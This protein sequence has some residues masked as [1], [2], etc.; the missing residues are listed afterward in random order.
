[1]S[2][3]KETA[4][5]FIILENGGFFDR[6]GFTN[7]KKGAIM[8]VPNKTEYPYYIGIGVFCAFA[9]AG[10]LFYFQNVCS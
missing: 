4:V 7:G 3:W 5:Y 8:K 2:S 1:M 10:A 6:L 9:S